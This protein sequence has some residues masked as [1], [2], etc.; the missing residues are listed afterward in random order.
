M[1]NLRLRT[2]SCSGLV[3]FE[4]VAAVAAASADLVGSSIFLIIFSASDSTASTAGS[5]LI[6]GLVPVSLEEDAADGTA[7]GLE[8]GDVVAVGEVVVAAEDDDDW[9]VC[10]AGAGLIRFIWLTIEEYCC[11]SI[12]AASSRT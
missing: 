2:S 4:R 9:A 11:I 12:T 10:V 6:L 8:I 7:P 3:S 1:A 5:F